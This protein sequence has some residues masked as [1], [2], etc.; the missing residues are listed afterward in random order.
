M[1]TVTAVVERDADV[2]EAGGN[3][4]VEHSRAS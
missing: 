2:R 3:V 4:I 1:K